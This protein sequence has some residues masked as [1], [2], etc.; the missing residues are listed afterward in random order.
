MTGNQS[1][2]TT[3]QYCLVDVMQGLNLKNSIGRKI[4]KENAAFHFGLNN[5]PVDFVTQIRVRRKHSHV[6]FRLT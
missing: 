3:Q 4:L 6:Q 1:V 2:T 5:S